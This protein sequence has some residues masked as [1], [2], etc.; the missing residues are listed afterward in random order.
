M[1]IETKDQE[2]DEFNRICA[3]HTECSGV[4]EGGGRC[5]CTGRCLGSKLARLRQ[6]SDHLY[7]SQSAFWSD[8]AHA[9]IKK[10]DH[11]LAFAGA[12]LNASNYYP[13]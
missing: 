13:T 6:A 12:V 4:M 1:H 3:E 2:R 5:G 7:V 11:D 10:R 8:Q 9:N